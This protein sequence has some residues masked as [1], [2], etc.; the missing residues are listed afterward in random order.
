MTHCSDSGEQ[1]EDSTDIHN[2]NQRKR[3]KQVSFPPDEQM[4]SGFADPRD[5]GPTA[6]SYESLNQV[7]EAYQQ[8]CRKNQVQPKGTILQQLQEH[9]WATS[10][11]LC[12]TAGA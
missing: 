3:R 7:I 5:A 2:K 4:V 12:S 6:H 9:I 8:S 11:S 10:V 1:S